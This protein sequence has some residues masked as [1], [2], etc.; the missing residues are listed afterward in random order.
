MYVIDFES[1]QW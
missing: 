1:R